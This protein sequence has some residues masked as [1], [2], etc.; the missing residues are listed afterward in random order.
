MG[1]LCKDTLLHQ[2]SITVLDNNYEDI[3]SISLTNNRTAESMG[4]CA[5]YLPPIKSS[6]GDKHIEFFN[7]MKM[8]VMKLQEFDNFVICGDFNSRTGNA[9]DFDSTI[10]PLQ[11][12]PRQTIDCAPCNSF[13]KALIEFTNV[14]DLCL[15]DLA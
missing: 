6:R 10:Y 14:C 15:Q 5:C 2:F 9:L 3:I 8:I 7:I 12:L 1:I 4:I 11:L 13:G